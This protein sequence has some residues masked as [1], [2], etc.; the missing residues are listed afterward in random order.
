[1]IYERVAKVLR[2]GGR[3][4]DSGR[5]IREQQRHVGARIPSPHKFKP[6]ISQ[7][8]SLTGEVGVEHELSAQPMLVAEKPCERV[9]ASPKDKAHLIAGRG[10]TPPR[11]P[12]GEVWFVLL[13]LVNRYLPVKVLTTWQVDIQHVE[14]FML[15]SWTGLV[16]AKVAQS[17]TRQNQFAH[18]GLANRYRIHAI[19]RCRDQLLRAYPSRPEPRLFRPRVMAV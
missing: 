19:T 13:R 6:A 1:V 8:L 12:S 3:S 17:A 9:G 14:I 18:I 11:R 2:A 10:I 5:P 7:R 4:S 16:E 15:T